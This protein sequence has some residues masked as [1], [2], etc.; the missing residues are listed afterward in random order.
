[1]DRKV[2][3]GENKSAFNILTDKPIGNRPLGIFEYVLK[4]LLTIWRT[5]LVCSRYWL[6]DG[7]S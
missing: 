7:V 1:M 4:K 5:G 2:A 3:R 6:L